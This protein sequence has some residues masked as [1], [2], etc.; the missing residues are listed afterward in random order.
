MVL[1]Q[2][3]AVFV[4]TLFGVFGLGCDRGSSD[5][6]P[7]FEITVADPEARSCDVL[8]EE[9]SLKV[10]D[11]TFPDEVMG[12]FQHRSPRLAVSFFNKDNRSFKG[13]TARVYLTNKGEIVDEPDLK[14]V[15]AV[16]FNPEG[17]ELEKADIEIALK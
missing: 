12:S 8:I 15:S 13:Y 11:V 2:W 7:V 6:R 9:V 14:M 16:C 3:T 1:N 17:N 4:I 10:D 5:T